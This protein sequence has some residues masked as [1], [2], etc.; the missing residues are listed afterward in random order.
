[1]S[2]VT[3]PREQRRGSYATSR[4][5]TRRRARPR[6]CSRSST[7]TRSRA[8]RSGSSSSAAAGRAGSDRRSR[9]PPRSRVY[10]S[11]LRFTTLSK[12]LLLSQNVSYNS[13]D[14]LGTWSTNTRSNASNARDTLD[15]TLQGILNTPS[16]ERTTTSGLGRSSI[17]MQA[18]G[19]R[20]GPSCSS[21]SSQRLQYLRR[22]L[23]GDPMLRSS[24]SKLPSSVSSRTVLYR[25][26]YLAFGRRS[27]D[28][29]RTNSVKSNP[30]HSSL[31]LHSS[32]NACTPT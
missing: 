28:K 16:R 31:R 1:M 11:E 12:Y 15:T 26:F 17:T 21:A 22:V 7:R 19:G 13:F 5:K 10:T 3:P 23:A 25:S 20:E 4:Q 2:A 6:G 14:G 29:H 32:R 18:V 24:V 9:P 8:R 30:C 27:L